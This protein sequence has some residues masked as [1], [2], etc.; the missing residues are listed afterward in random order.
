[1]R[2]RSR[3]VRGG[4]DR[5]RRHLLQRTAYL[6]GGL[7]LA[8]A[9]PALRGGSRAATVSSSQLNAW[10][11]IGSD[12]SIT[13]LVDRSE[14]GQ[15]VYTALPTLLAEELE[16]DPSRV[17]IVAA[18][19]GEVYVNALN[20]GQITGT[21]NSV[22]DAWE[23]LRKAGAQARSMLI[24]SA[25][26]R[27]RVDPSG[28][29]ASNGRITS[30]SGQTASYGE[31]AEAAAKL[32]V[33]KE[34]SLKSPAEFRLIGK[35]LARL[36]TPSKVDGSAEFGI[37]V[38]LPGMLYASIALCPELGGTVASVDSA[39][40]LAMPSVRRVVPTASAVIVVAE[41]FWHAKK[42]RD[43]LRIVWAPGP[44]AQLDN[45]AIWSQLNAAAAK[46]G[47]SALSSD[48]VAASLKGG[49]AAE[50]LKRAAR[51]FSAVYELPLL[52]HATMEPMNC[53]AD[54]RGDGCDVY[55]GTQ[56]QQLAQAA[57]A[58][59][60]GLKASQVNVHTTLLG[61]GFGRRLDV[62]FV[63][64]A[65]AAS[66]A[67]GAPVK[68]IW[69]REDDMTHDVYRPPAREAV[70]AGLDEHGKLSAW[71]LH[72]VSPSIT[73]RYDPTSKD[74]FDSVIEYVQ[75]FPYGV[76]N[77]D[78]RYTRQEIGI[79]VGYLRSVSH[80]PNC[81]AIE[82]SIDEIAALVSKDPF[83]FR[84][85]L[86]AGKPRHLQVLKVVADRSGW[87]HAPKGH[88][89]GIA[90]MEGYTSHIAQVAEVSVEAGRLKIHKITCVIDC[91]QTVNPRIVESQLESG[92]VY[93][94]TAALWGNVTLRSG[95]VQQRNFNDQRVL[96]INELPILDVHVIT[97][98][99]RPGGVGEAAVPPVAPSIC[100]AIFAATGKR[101]RTLP[102]AAHKLI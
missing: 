96:R 23:K 48:T 39:A 16:V 93:G 55:V 64:A 77:F 44:N 78:L 47:V 91:G 73:S 30:A 76:P 19:V 56:A 58:E 70:Q 49:H 85:E 41:H 14:M 50:A 97:S 18:P 5:S 66:K 81:F 99:A 63:P 12:D 54:V 79:D 94:L 57:A 9:L 100:N 46:P 87:G 43:A 98:G 11:R 62:D 68:L 22:A 95:C 17:K 88:F 25:A 102:I 69:T 45:A 28:C 26:R 71:T 65:V 90:F 6:G 31:L 35:P 24:T 27:W 15:G 3:Q 92:I 13:M 83:E 37:D 32:P 101:L 8:M 38:K 29:R 82:S 10:L 80:A 42:A 60:A 21:S 75:N 40:A 84:R 59:A 89:Q 53:T 33:P 20:G 7:V 67:V 2:S 61:G 4:I 51:T 52:A 86:L 72:I 74:P 34:V 36:D 1:M